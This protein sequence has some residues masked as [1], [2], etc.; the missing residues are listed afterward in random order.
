MF[1]TVF[2]HLV[3]SFVHRERP[4]SAEEVDLLLF[5]ATALIYDAQTSHHNKPSVCVQ[6]WACVCWLSCLQMTDACV[7]TLCCQCRPLALRQ[8]GECRGIPSCHSFPIVLIPHLLP[9][10]PPSSLLSPLTPSS[11][12][13]PLLPT[14]SSSNTL[15][16]LMCRILELKRFHGI[17]SKQVSQI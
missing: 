1:L 7:L 17:S 3:I 12:P 8:T 6:T 15:M 14:F 16:I 9:P 4:A 2:T 10:P 13:P 11:F 5:F